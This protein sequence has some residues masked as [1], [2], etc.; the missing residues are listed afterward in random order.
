[1]S[2]AAGFGGHRRLPGFGGTF[3]QLWASHRQWPEER[4]DE[5]F[6]YLLQLGVGEVVVQWSR[7][8]G[9][10]FD[11]QVKRLVKANFS[12]WMG[13]SYESNW[14]QAQT[15]ESIRRAILD[16]PRIE[17]VKGFY[18]PQELEAGE[19]SAPGRREE[20]ALAIKFVRRQFRPLAVGGFTN[21]RGRPE[22]LG[23][24]WRNLQHESGYDRLL[25]QD[26][27]GAGK[28]PIADWD[29]WCRALAWGAGKRLS[30]VVETFTGSGEGAAWRGVPAEAGRIARQLEIARRW[31]RSGVVAFSLPE[32][33][34]PLGGRDAEALFLQVRTLLSDKGH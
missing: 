24:F 16:V 17:G 21:C 25:F 4:W 15:G 1:M 9:A 7:Y 18:L 28:V 33:V 8:D 31:S 23:R 30:V 26:G 19:W 14:W 3:L 6:S 13:L 20:L 5:L 34:T 10:G 29:A 27:V 11:E 12:V 2:M 22:D 32:Y